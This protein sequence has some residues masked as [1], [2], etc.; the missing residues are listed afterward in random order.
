MLPKRR[1]SSRINEAVHLN[2]TPFIDILICLILFLLSAA[3]FLKLAVVDTNLPQLANAANLNAEKKQEEKLIVAVRIDGNG[4][5]VLR[6]GADKDA[7]RQSRW[8]RGGDLQGKIPKEANG[9][10]NV[11][12]LNQRMQAIKDAYPEAK[13]VMIIPAGNVSYQTIIQAMDATREAPVPNDP[14]HRLELFPDAIIG[15]SSEEGGV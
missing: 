10:F 5:E 7:K 13:T 8:E 14:K 15:H 2:I 1:V 4:F 9:G 6:V 3:A 12:A 11:A